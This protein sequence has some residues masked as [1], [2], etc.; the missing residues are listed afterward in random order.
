MKYFNLVW[1]ALF[2]KPISGILT[3]ATLFIAF[4]LFGMLNSV[5]IGFFTRY[6]FFGYRQAHRGAQVFNH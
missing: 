4:L 6:R 3:L 1:A 2:R 5:S